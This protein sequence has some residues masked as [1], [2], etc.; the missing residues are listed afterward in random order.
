MRSNS[1]LHVISVIDDKV[2][3][4]KIC[5]N[6]KVNLKDIIVRIFIF[7]I[8]NDNYDSI[9]EIMNEKQC[10]R[11]NILLIDYAKLLFIRNI[12]QKKS[13]FRRLH[14]IINRTKQ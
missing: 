4:E 3:Y 7:V 12:K 10:F 8:K 14:L 2:L 9:F 5:K 13:N 11:L 6:A 1:K